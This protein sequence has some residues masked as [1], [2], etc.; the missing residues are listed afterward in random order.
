MAK[1]E[2]DKKSIQFGEKPRLGNNAEST[3]AYEQIIKVVKPVLKPGEFLELEQYFSGYGEINGAKALS[4]P[5]TSIFSETESSVISGI[6]DDSGQI[7]CGATEIPFVNGIIISLLGIRSD[8][9][10]SPTHF[11]DVSHQK[12]DGVPVVFTESKSGNY[13][14]VNYKLKTRKNIQPGEYSLD[15]VFTYHNGEKWVT[16]SKVVKFKIQNFIERYALLITCFAFIAS[17]SAIIRFSILPLIKL[18]SP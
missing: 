7:F 1:G 9:W 14:P 16:T 13:A 15:F 17:I 4:F 10:K 18:L 11:F 2:L 3:G 12:N 5:S 8:K 6:K